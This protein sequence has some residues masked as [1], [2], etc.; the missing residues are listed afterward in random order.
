MSVYS[1]S[2]HYSLFTLWFSCQIMYSIDLLF[3]LYIKNTAVACA[4]SQYNFIQI[5]I[6]IP[7]RIWLYR[8][9]LAWTFN[10]NSWKE[11]N[12]KKGKLF[13]SRSIFPVKPQ[14]HP[15]NKLFKNIMMDY[16]LYYFWG[17]MFKNYIYWINSFFKW[18]HLPIY[19]GIKIRKKCN[20][21]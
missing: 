11:K 16:L 20:F 13:Q 21:T 6:K 2:K 5:I 17:S 10:K 7:L 14:V 12:N 1:H 4:L 19:C 3:W 18:F 15:W 8:I 9:I